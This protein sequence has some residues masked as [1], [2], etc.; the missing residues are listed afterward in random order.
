MLRPIV[1]AA[2]YRVVSDAD[3]AEADLAILSASV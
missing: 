3:E 2:G 1:E